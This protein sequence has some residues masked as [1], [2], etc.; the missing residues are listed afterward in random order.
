MSNVIMNF[1]DILDGCGGDV[2][3]LTSLLRLSKYPDLIVASGTCDI[4]SDNWTADPF[5][6]IPSCDGSFEIT[7]FA[8]DLKLSNNAEV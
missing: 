3:T 2:A 4:K 8:S 1:T 7:W 6:A 5:H